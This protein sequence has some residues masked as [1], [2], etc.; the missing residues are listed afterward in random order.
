MIHTT[1]EG[2]AKVLPLILGDP[3]IWTFLRICGPSETF[4][5][6]VVLIWLF[7]QSLELLSPSV[8]WSPSNAELTGSMVLGSMDFLAFLLR[9]WRYWKPA[10]RSTCISIPTGTSDPDACDLRSIKGNLTTSLSYL[11]RYPAL[12]ETMKREL[13]D[14]REQKKGSNC[15]HANARKCRQNE[16]L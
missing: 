1:I 12:S 2:M 16:S 5:W 15:L 6:S 8:G 14:W 10:G 13:D 7:L 11:N 9:T 4:L 3:S